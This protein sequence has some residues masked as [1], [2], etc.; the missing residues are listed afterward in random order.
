MILEGLDKYA[1]SLLR[2]DPLRKP[3]FLRIISSLQLPEGSRGLDVGCGLGLQDLLLAEAVGNTGHVTGMDISESF[4]EAARQISRQSGLADRLTF[5]IGSWDQ[6]PGDDE[7]FDWVWSADAAGYAA[8]EPVR[9][10]RELR[11]VIK[12]G[13]RLILLFWSSQCLLPGYPALEAELNTTRAGIAPFSPN[14]DPGVHY[15]R[16]SGWM[17][18]AGLVD[19][20][21]DTF[22]HTVYAPL[23]KGVRE[24]L[25][26]LFE[27]RWGT[28]EADVPA[29]TWRAY[30]NLCSPASPDDILNNPDYCAF[31]TY[32]VFSG[33]VPANR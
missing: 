3:V 23:D 24:A 15:L 5:R 14:A 20:H 9:V 33:T 21:A 32:S 30:Q 13:G 26:D 28:A 17:R 2:S 19:I 29:E 7:A 18:A 27:M 31:F 6:I 16:C 11:R 10:V 8:R 25:S 12:P 22:A 4:L 1:Q